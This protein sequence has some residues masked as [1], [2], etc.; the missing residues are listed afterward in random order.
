MACGPRR[1]ATCNG[2]R[3]NYPRAAFTFT[4][5]R[6]GFPACI[7]SAVMRCGRCA[8]YGATTPK[9]PTSS[10]PSAADQSAPSVSTVSSSASAR[11][12]RCHSPS[13][14]T[15]F[16]MP[17]GSSSPTMATTRGP[18][19]TTSGTRTSSTRSGTPK[20]RPTASRTFGGADDDGGRQVLA[21]CSI[22]L[23]A[24]RSATEPP[25]REVTSPQAMAPC[26]ACAPS[27][28]DKLPDAR[29]ELD[30]PDH[31]DLET[32]VAQGGTQVVLDGNG[33]GQSTGRALLS[34]LCLRQSFMRD[35]HL[36]NY[37]NWSTSSVVFPAFPNFR[38]RAC[39]LFQ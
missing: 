15:C 21:A 3:S 29:L 39:N 22:K 20:W 17:A 4:G 13:T 33:L 11:P 37:F 31:A 12:P 23:A 1:S 27:G 24:R 34:R 6:M 7:R 35:G 19:S 16:A 25:R 8:S 9:T 38:L 30:R 36:M 28:R 14:R 5:S 10:F 32:E 18:C 26:P 2:S